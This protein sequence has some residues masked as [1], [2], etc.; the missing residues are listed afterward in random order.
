MSDS[1]WPT[2]KL[3]EDER[4]AIY[5]LMKDILS[6][7]PD[8]VESNLISALNQHL[9]SKEAT[10]QIL[11]DEIQKKEPQFRILAGTLTLQNNF[12]RQFPRVAFYEVIDIVRELKYCF[13]TDQRKTIKKLSAQVILR[14]F[15]TLYFEFFILPTRRKEGRVYVNKFKKFF[16]REDIVK[17]INT[18]NIYPR[19]IFEQYGIDLGVGDEI[20]K[21][22]KNTLDKF[23]S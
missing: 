14:L 11:K 13:Y 19:F 3:G 7:F 8:S 2:K 4:D 22:I 21:R 5:F 15:L 6:C 18:T 1:T 12:L 9:I 20:Q 10:R 16:F 17:I 23:Y